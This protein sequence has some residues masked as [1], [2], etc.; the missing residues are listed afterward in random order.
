MNNM[1]AKVRTLLSGAAIFLAGMAC[2]FLLLARTGSDISVRPTVSGAVATSQ[3]LQVSENG[4][5]PDSRSPAASQ[6]Q[7]RLTQ[8]WASRL[9]QAADGRAF[10]IEAWRHPESGGRYYASYAAGH[11]QG[12][13]LGPAASQVQPPVDDVSGDAYVR[14]IAAFNR[15]KA[16]CEQFTDE[17]LD[18]FSAAKSAGLEAVDALFA[19]SARLAA[20]SKSRDLAAR[21][22]AIQEVLASQDPLLV[23]QLGPRLVVFGSATGGADFYFDGQRYPAS[24]DP[25]VA[26]ALYLLPCGLGLACDTLH[27]LPLALQCASGP[28]CYADRFEK[29]RV[30]LAGGDEAKYQRIITAYQA[31]LAAV[32][33]GEGRKFVPE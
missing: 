21:R 25:P 19:V 1:P 6:V 17:E 14:K 5:S 20:A 24:S 9:A 16:F 28:V 18:T 8:N 7:K 32:K 27:D 2:V 3:S 22:S 23:D 10:A 4:S 30:E 11:C 12:L 31:M 13:R 26:A 33:A 29:T 15:I